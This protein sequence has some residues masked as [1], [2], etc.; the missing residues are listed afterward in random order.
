M[1]NYW[2][3]DYALNR[4]SAGIVYRFADG[5]VEISLEDYLRENPEKTEEDFLT[6]KAISD[7]IYHQQFS[8]D[9]AYLRRSSPLHTQ[10]GLSMPSAE[11]MAE[12]RS[13]Q[14]ELEQ[15]QERLEQLLQSG[16]LTEVQRRRFKLYCING[17]STRQIARRE[18]VS[19]CSVWECLQACQKKFEKFLKKHP[20]TPPNSR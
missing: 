12:A 7:E 6:L 18:G 5:V 16:L 1:K 19:Q 15:M 20:V 10:V 8:G 17:L 11:E 3:S 4:K 13:V 14:E 2:A 9:K